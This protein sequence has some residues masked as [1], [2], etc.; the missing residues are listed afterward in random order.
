MKV[1]HR[2]IEGRKGCWEV[3]DTMNRQSSFTDAKVGMHEDISVI[4]LCVYLLN[5]QY[6]ER[7]CVL[8]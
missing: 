3:W 7:H 4:K 2:F 8:Y 5:K 1:S 6:G